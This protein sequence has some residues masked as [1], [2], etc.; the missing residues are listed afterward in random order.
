MPIRFFANGTVEVDTL[1]EALVWE[2]RKRR[3]SKPRGRPK[4]RAVTT[5]AENPWEAFYQDISAPEC[6]KIRKILALILGRGQTGIGVDEL[7]NHVGDP[8]GTHTTGSISGMFLKAK[9]AGLTPADIV[10]RGEDKR[11][12]PGSLLLTHDPP[13]P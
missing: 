13:V 4:Q 9:K 11:F 10:V 1:N 12:R 5:V 2:H 3:S 6:A 7:K 8:T